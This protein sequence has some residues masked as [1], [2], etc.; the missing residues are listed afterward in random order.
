MKLEDVCAV[1][2]DGDWIESK[3]QSNE[4]IRLVQT[5]NIGEGVY[6]EKEARAKYISEDTFSKLKCTEIFPGDILVSRLPEPVGRACIIPEKKERMI[7]AVD[8]TICRPDEAL[9]IK[10]Y[11]CYFMRSNVYYNRLLGNITGTTRKRISRKRLGNVELQIPSKDEQKNV[12][13]KLDFLVKVIDS[14]K[15]ELKLLDDLI[16]A[17]FVEMFGE[18]RNNPKGW[19]TI[20]LEKLA[21]VGSSKRVFVEELQGE[22]VPFYRG[23]E[24]GV[25]A[26]G[27]QITPE[28]YIT[29][30]H[31][32]LLVKATGAPK[33]GDLLMPSICSDGRIWIIDT[34]SP[35]YIKDGRVLWV[36]PTSA[37][38]DSCYLQ[39]VLKEKIMTDYGSIASGTTFAELKIFA[40]KALHVMLPPRALQEQFAAFVAQVDKSKL[41]NFYT[42]YNYMVK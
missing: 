25:L 34:D 1:F 5:G 41:M 35:F 40:L 42:Q 29:E 8:C 23:T 18:S 31:Y 20:L 13:E 38:I 30:E 4:G 19:D 33:K 14:R 39:H 15:K 11:L 21:D 22:G 16:K 28:L 6:L 2:T 26:E 7:T 9:I 32:S 17:R 3:D 12:V 10:E 36:H 27:Q 24:I 37:E